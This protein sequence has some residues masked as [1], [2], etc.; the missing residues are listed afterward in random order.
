VALA[1]ESGGVYITI[2]DA[3]TGMRALAKTARTRGALE[4]KEFDRPDPGPNEVLVSVDYAGLCG[5][6]ASIYT[7]EGEYDRMDLPTVIG[8]EYTGTVVEVGADVTDLS[9]GQRVAERPIRGCGVC[10]FCRS[11]TST[12]C[13]NAAI[14]GVDHHGAYGE[15]VVAPAGSLNVVSPDV[16]ARR[17]AVVEPASVG[18]RAVTRHSRV[19]AGSS[20]LVLGPGPIGILT[21]QVATTQGGDVVVVGV[22]ADS[23]Y[24][25]PL[26]A[27]LGLETLNVETADWQAVCDE[28]TDGLGYDV[29]FDTTGHPSGLQ[30]AIDAVRKGGQIVV[31]GLPGETTVPYSTLVRSEVDIQCTYASDWQDFE[32]ALSLIRDGG[33]TVDPMLE[34]RFSLLDADE[35]FEIFI[36]G[37]A[38]KPVF[39]VGEL[40]K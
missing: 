10:H 20:V 33:L 28:H 36:S 19:R 38:C 22:S 23:D 8:H 21:A 16:P 4:L 5:S 25:L 40:R 11:G 12:L 24:R 3:Q 9:E 13:E 35:A 17:A 27:D 7:F 2:R 31:V 37:Q 18:V 6:D 39:N 1:L 14:T 26:A 30:T 29:V 34:D 15:F 32:R